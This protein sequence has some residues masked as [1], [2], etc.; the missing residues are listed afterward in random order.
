MW[1]MLTQLFNLE[2]MTLK[3]CSRTNILLSWGPLTK[4][5][6]LSGVKTFKLELGFWARSWREAR[7]E[8]SLNHSCLTCMCQALTLILFLGSLL[9]FTKTTKSTAKPN[10]EFVTSQHHVIRCRT[11]KLNSELNCLIQL[12]SNTFWEWTT[13]RPSFQAVKLGLMTTIVSFQSSETPWVWMIYSK[14]GI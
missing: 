6:G 11:R 14:P 3:G 5:L 7:G 12:R 13:N 10:L 2:G 8:Y 1:R 9:T 4:R